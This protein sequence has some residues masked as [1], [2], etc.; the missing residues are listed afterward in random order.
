MGLSDHTDQG[1]DGRYLLAASVL[2]LLLARWS[3]LGSARNFAS[4]LAAD[5]RRGLLHGV[6]AVSMAC[7]RQGN[8]GEEVLN[9]LVCKTRDMHNQQHGVLNWLVFEAH[10]CGRH[11]RGFYSW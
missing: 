10:V 11:W 3:G 5:H 1:S 8:D 4:D 6:A 2:Y 7:L 9:G